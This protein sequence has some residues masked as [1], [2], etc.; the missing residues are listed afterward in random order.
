M[1]RPAC[2]VPVD[3]YRSDHW[4]LALMNERRGQP[5]APPEA[6]FRPATTEE[7]AECVAWARGQGLGVVAR[8]GG[9]GVCGGAVP[10]E[11]TVVIDLTRIDHIVVDSERTT[12]RAGAGV[13]GPALEAALA[14]EGL[15]IG[16]VPQSL[17]IST[18]GGWV[19]TKAMGQLSTKY[20][21]I[22]GRLL[23]LTA[24]LADGSVVSNRPVPR[25]SQGPDWWRLFL[26]SEG[27]LGIVTEVI[28]E[29]FPLPP[30]SSWLEVNLDSFEDGFDLARSFMGS[31]LRPCVARTYDSADA[32]VNFGALG[33]S[34]PIGLFR[35]EG[36]QE[37]VEA[38]H[39]LAARIAGD[40]VATLGAGEHWWEHRFKA[41]DT[42]RQILAG[43]G[44]LGSF[45][46]VDTLEVAAFWPDLGPLYRSVAKGLEG[47]VDVLMA[48]CS[49]LYMSGGNIYF[50]FLIASATSEEDAVE[51]YRSVWQ[52][53]GD[54]VS[55]LGATVSHHHGIGLL[56]APWLDA[57]WGSGGQVSRSIKAAL[58]PDGSMNPGKLF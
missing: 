46:V 41:A 5:F 12:V 44:A 42:Y 45:G 55:G 8:G 13:F 11:R 29:A 57:E 36:H 37:M 24:V 18:V 25:A 7:V 34:S 48:H 32:S 21:G 43:E 30:H 49:H 16:H 15:S 54:T 38:E 4:A 27:T 19:A 58:D 14:A 26:G 2:E 1:N 20:G 52:V 17:Q 28:L 56:K 10:G 50:T 22:E 3:G 9:S 31:G 40:R 35:F 47:Q 53:A 39:A 51:R 23:G 6:A 33:I